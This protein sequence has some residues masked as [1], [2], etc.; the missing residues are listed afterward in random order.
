M[1]TPLNRSDGRRMIL[2]MRD[3]LR[4]LAEVAQIPYSENAVVSTTRQHV[5]GETIP[6]DD[7]DV[8]VVRLHGQ[9]RCRLSR[10]PYSNGHVHGRRCEN[11][12]LR[13]TP[14]DVLYRRRMALD[15]HVHI[16]MNERRGWQRRAHDVERVMGGRSAVV[17]ARISTAKNT[18]ADDLE[19]VCGPDFLVTHHHQSH[20][21]HTVR[22]VRSTLHRPP[23]CASQQ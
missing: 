2:K 13:R 4:A 19:C 23:S 3:G 12:F 8:R 18:E 20:H 22:A 16:R 7:I 6:T 9:G 5:T 14:R 15:A 17:S 11:G 10:I 1:R 21:A